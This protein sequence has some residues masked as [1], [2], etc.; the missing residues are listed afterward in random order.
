MTNPLITKLERRDAL[1]VEERAALEHVLESPRTAPAGTHLLRQGDRPEKSTLLLSGF[2]ARYV[3]LAD[4]GRQYTQISLPGDFVDLHS[5]LMKQMDHGVVTL[6]D[7][8]VASADPGALRALTDRHPHLARLLW[9]ETV[10]D[11]GIH[12][13]W[14]TALGRRDALGRLA[15]IICETFK[16]LEHAG[17]AENLTFAL[18]ITQ[19]DL[20]D[21]I[22]LSPVHVN[23]TLMALRAM[24]A[25]EWKGDRC[26]ILDWERLSALAE[27]DPT[28]LRLHREPV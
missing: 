28:Y 2:A 23:R 15:L 11:G 4:G 20:A 1:S 6:T 19:V 22:G 7:C 10:I 21:V 13:Q 8:V 27:F 16:R 14:I 18:P 25:L 3:I 12:R 5:F 17:Q 26:T 24:R 9:L